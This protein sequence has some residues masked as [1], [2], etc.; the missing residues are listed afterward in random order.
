MISRHLP[1]S[2]DGAVDRRRILRAVLTAAA[3]GLVFAALVVPDQVGRLKAGQSVPTAFL[4]IPLEGLLGAALLLAL[5]R[6]PRRPVA[7]LLGVGLGVLTV[8]KV[9]NIGF[10]NVLGRR[11]NPV[12]DWPLLGNGYDYL[13]GTSGRVTAIGAAAGAAVLAAGVVALLT[14]SV[15]RLSGFVV[16]YPRP[17]ARAITAGV[18]AW[19]VF[20]L[21][22]TQLFVGAPVASDAAAVLARNTALQVPRAVQ[23]KKAFA[24][25][26]RADAFRDVPADRLLTGLRGKDVVFVF[27]E[28][29]GRAALQNSKIAALVDPALAAGAQGLAAAGFSARSGYLTSS[30]YGGGSWLAHATM[31]SGLWIDNE[32][33]YR[34]LVSG[35]RLTLPRL[36]QRAGWHTA[37]FEPG[38]TKAWPEGDFY[39]YRQVHDSRTMGYRGPKFAWSSMPD[40]YVFATFQRE[41]YGRVTQPVMA[42][43]TLTSS[44]T[45]WTVTPEMVEWDAVGDGAV[46]GPMAAA[47]EDAQT[48]RSNPARVRA[49]YGRSIAYSLTST[50][51]W[52]QR[53]GDDDLVLVVLGDH[54]A[55]PVVSG[56]SGRDVPIS[57]VTK[58]RAVLDR[59]AG[60]GWEDG[61]RPSRKAPVTRMDAFRDRFLTTFAAP[62]PARSAH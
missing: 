5:P 56:R 41:V 62:A 7:V 45:P 43:L 26:A 33:R 48:L 15:V 10:L 12:L 42:E 2:A 4:R 29:Y 34:Q 20:A 39:G 16:R 53:Y 36:F 37:A 57:V 8:L 60:W 27:V 18:A 46:F 22:G 32:Q 30:T 38:N 35:D 14:L 54:Q 21:V 50:L 24:A 3:A 61:L 9:F 1:T 52:A 31:H 28:S 47:A 40:Q 51:S 11:F 19:T 55:K 49:A 23:D 25:L 44:H 6:R 59:V 17:A 58:D 13:V